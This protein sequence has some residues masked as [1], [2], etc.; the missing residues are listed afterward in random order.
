MSRI[1]FVSFS[2]IRLIVFKHWVV[3]G[4]GWVVEMLRI[5][6]LASS[7]VDS[8]SLICWVGISVRSGSDMRSSMSAN[9]VK[10]C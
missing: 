6:F 10:V 8:M 2:F 9:S 1:R 4:V 7:T 5:S 3:L